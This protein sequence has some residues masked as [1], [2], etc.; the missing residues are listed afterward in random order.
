M[1]HTTQHVQISGPVGIKSDKVQ[2]GV[3]FRGELAADTQFL[4]KA[5]GCKMS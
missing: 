5:L 2:L 4:P 1:C 3:T